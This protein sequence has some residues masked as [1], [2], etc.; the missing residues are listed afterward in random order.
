[1]C[2]RKKFNLIRVLM[3][4]T[5]MSV[6]NVAQAA[7][8]KT[9][10]DAL[11]A[12]YNST[13]GA[14]WKNK[15]GWLGT[16]NECTW[17]GIACNGDAVTSISL[18]KNQLSGSIS[19][20][21]GQLSQ[22]HYLNLE[23][24][25]LSGTIPSALGQLRQ[26]EW[27]NLN[28]NLLSGT[29][30]SLPELNNLKGL[31]LNN[32]QLTGSIPAT[33]N[34]SSYLRHLNL[35]KNELNGAIPATLGQLTDLTY[36]NLENNQLSGPIPESLGQLIHLEELSFLDN[37]LSGTIPDTFKNLKNLKALYLFGNHLSGAIPS[38][39]GQLSKLEIIYLATNQ[40]T[41]P[42]PASLGQL[43]NLTLLHLYEN[44]LSGTIPNEL[45]QLTKLTVLGLANNCL[46]TDNPALIA[47]V[48][49]FD[50]NWQSQAKDCS[51]PMPVPAPQPIVGTGYIEGNI[52]NA[53][54]R[55][56]LVSVDVNFTGSSARTQQTDRDGH[57]SI[58]LG[59]GRYDVGVSLTGYKT[60]TLNLVLEANETRLG[61]FLLTPTAGCANIRPANTKK[62]IIIAGSGPKLPSTDNPIWAST[63]ALADRAYEA[64]S[65]QGFKREDIHYFS[66]GPE[67]TEHDINGI[68]ITPDE[69]NLN[70]LQQE[71]TRWSGGVEQIV[72]Y[73]IGHG[74]VGN[75]QLNR[76][77]L[78]TPELLKPWLN[79]LQAKL[80]NDQSGQPGK[81]SLIIDACKSGSFIAPL[82]APNRYIVTSTS[83][84]LDA[85]VANKDGS[86]SFSYHFW[87]Q[88]G[89]KDGWLSTAFQQARQSMSSELVASGGKTQK[90]MLDA[91][92]SGGETTE[93]D[94][95]AVG[96]YCYGDCK[97]HASVM[98][99]IES[100][101]PLENL[102][103]SLSSLLKVR[104]SKPI[105]KAWVN[106]Q[107]P[108]YRFPADGTALASILQINL[109]CNDSPS[110]EGHY[111]NFNLND[112][113]F[114][115]FYVQD[116]DNNIATPHTL[117]LFQN[118]LPQS[119]EKKNPNAVY[120]ISTGV[121][122]I[123]DVLVNGLHFYAELQNQSTTGF[124][125]TLNHFY[126]LNP[127]GNSASAV[128]DGDV[129]TMPRVFA[130]GT[131][132]QVTL[133]LQAGQFIL[134]GGSVVQ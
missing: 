71:L 76:D 84:D 88:V 63:Q 2:Y 15:T 122:T 54:N 112:D 90:A 48:S 58:K 66:A 37:Q 21:L 118:G 29:I 57:Y 69:A 77:T 33:L 105:A 55:K 94:Y 26:L 39:L 32:N 98:P 50:P 132:Y 81:L 36:L 6:G 131:H 120:E 116:K 73:M 79:A 124:Q 17:F 70:N 27:F 109:T 35:A 19:Q 101:S 12:F 130:D 13:N 133:K 25:Q 128:F 113:Y 23:D 114:I 97:A 125:F 80:I 99:V 68:K 110:C 42:I 75:F 74:G 7:I 38:F 82:A 67:R 30:P 117:K 78:L 5:F 64:L 92:G 65:L 4:L 51:A 129:L 18:E 107:R 62:A 47:F 34:Q 10:R 60:D 106:I 103:G 119:N 83:A 102:N 43:S 100:I 108:D 49:R 46:S 14:N 86:N 22:L 11:I 3:L 20:A 8:P 31:Y 24:N 87:G 126:G 111:N 89:F 16:E 121:L 56:P 52:L 59:S 28:K 72:V 40:F 96:S 115:T 85:I 9:E 41:G 104:A 1:M 95:K 91:D 127:A 45:Q 61:N 93:E 123:K 134:I 44:K 53:C